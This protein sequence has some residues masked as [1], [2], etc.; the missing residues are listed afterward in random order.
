MFFCC[1]SEHDIIE[2]NCFTFHNLFSIPLSWWEDK[3]YM[4]LNI[5][6]TETADMLQMEFPTNIQ[7]V[8]WKKRKV[9]SFTV[10]RWNTN[11]SEVDIISIF[12]SNIFVGILT[13]W[14]TDTYSCDITATNLPGKNWLIHT[15]ILYSYIHQITKWIDR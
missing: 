15:A 7:N 11:L 4:K 8:I 12:A 13:Y 2:S 5:F 1:W 9:S 6:H 10:E 14:V 3:K